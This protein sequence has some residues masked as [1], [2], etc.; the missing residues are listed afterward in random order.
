MCVCVCVYVC[1]VSTQDS[2][3]HPRLLVIL[4]LISAFHDIPPVPKVKG[5]MGLVRTVKCN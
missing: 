3:T 2:M 5:H 1:V 4:T